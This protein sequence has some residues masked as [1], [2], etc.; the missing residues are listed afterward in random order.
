MFQLNL[1]MST[2][3]QMKMFNLLTNGII[4]NLLRYYCEN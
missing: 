1:N 4:I 2:K 3:I